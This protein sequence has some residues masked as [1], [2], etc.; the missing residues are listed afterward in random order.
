MSHQLGPDRFALAVDSIQ[1]DSPLTLM[2]AT[3]IP[4]RL[5]SGVLF[6]SGLMLAA[7]P[8]AGAAEAA[9][10]PEPTGES[11][12][13]AEHG[14]IDLAREDSNAAIRNRNPDAQWFPEAG[15]GLFIHWGICSVKGL[16]ISWS[17]IEGLN[18]KHA[19][20]T[21]REYFAQAK[22]FNPQ[23]YDADRWIRAAKD[24][25]FTYAVLTTRHH[26]GFALWPSRF[27][28]FDTQNYLGGRDLV[29][30]FVEACRKYGLK[31]GFY[32]SPPNWY[33]ERDTKNFSYHLPDV[34]LD[35]DLRPRTAFP[36]AEAQAKH[37]A[38]Y[39]VMVRGQIEEL[40]TRYG[41]VDLLW[42]DGRAP[43]PN[44][45]EII[46]LQRLRELQPQ[47]VVNSRMHGQG[48]FI[49]YERVLK[50]NKVA[51]EWAEY[52]NTWTPYWSHV[53]SAR[54]RAPGFIL[55]QYAQCR[56]WHINYLPGVGPTADG[57]FVEEIYRQFAVVG[58]WMRNHA[59]AVKGARPLPAGETASVPAT[60]SGSNRF[61]FAIP[62]FGPGEPTE[63]NQ[64]PAQDEIL[65]LSGA[66]RPASVT[67]LPSGE[68]LEFTQEG[69]VLS[70][71]L[72]AAVRTPLVDVVQVTAAPST[73]IGGTR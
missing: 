50:T 35:Q 21:P 26:E 17:M 58:G 19:Q 6:F 51:T 24:A 34:S 4:F 31:V 33:F 72:P 38:E 9:H 48:D 63:D 29:K 54:L 68:K 73:E 45:G 36:S 70:I 12:V 66:A 37:R 22:E 56:A 5:G 59:R 11:A 25:G 2:K 53:P 3:H 61:L 28:G 62:R 46:P 49:T 41:K 42:F 57:E 60:A 27:G 64:L 1:R 23:R 67:L 13:S 15:L 18:G 65:T 7:G 52:C 14:G 16:N 47:I 69:A 10:R 71:R 32:Y 44:P 55:G 30:D 8:C 39:A 43:V 20:I 40:L